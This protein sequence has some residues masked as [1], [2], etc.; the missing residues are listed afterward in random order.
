MFS[1]GSGAV[2]WTSKKQQAVA[3]SSIEAE[4]Q[5]AVKASCEAVW[6]RCMLADIHV[7]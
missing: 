7:S 5:G 3:L 4:Y 1:L 6:L 2:T